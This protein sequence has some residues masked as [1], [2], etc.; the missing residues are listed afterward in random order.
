M[1]KILA[2][3]NENFPD[4]D[5]YARSPDQAAPIREREHAFRRPT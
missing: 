3:R 5:E 1:R 2:D 4:R